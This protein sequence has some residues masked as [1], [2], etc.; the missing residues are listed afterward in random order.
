MVFLHAQKYWMCHLRMCRCGEC[1]CNIYIIHVCVCFISA[2]VCTSNT[3]IYIYTSTCM[4]IYLYIHIHVHTIINTRTYISFMYVNYIY[5]YKNDMHICLASSSWPCY[6][7]PRL[8]SKDSQTPL[9]CCLPLDPSVACAQKCGTYF[10]DLRR[11][12][13]AQSFVFC[14]AALGL[15]KTPCK[16][17]RSL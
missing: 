12:C 13:S 17:W 2:H 16:A 9:G 5:M 14:F 15:L 11:V 8:R 7:F 10:F 3:Y 1:K 6:S 4:Y